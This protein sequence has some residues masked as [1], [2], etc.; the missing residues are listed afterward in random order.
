MWDFTNHAS[1]S[2]HWWDCLFAPLL[3]LEGSTRCPF[4]IQLDPRKSDAVLLQTHRL[5]LS[6]EGN[7]DLTSFINDW[8]RDRYYS[9]WQKYLRRWPTRLRAEPGQK[10]YY[11]PASRA[12]AEIAREH[13]LWHLWQH[14]LAPIDRSSV[15][16]F[17]IVFFSNLFLNFKHARKSPRG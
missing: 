11:Q 17:P 15:R 3:E 12:I 6:E 2:C 14:G 4:R 9:N 13:W 1:L 5:V 7:R 8:T 10:E 16:A